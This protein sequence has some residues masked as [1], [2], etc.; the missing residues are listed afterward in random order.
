MVSKI[1]DLN[2]LYYIIVW[3]LTC[4]NYDICVIVVLDSFQF[5]NTNQLCSDIND[6]YSKI[7]NNID[8]RKA[9][10]VAVDKFFLGRKKRKVVHRVNEEYISATH[11]KGCFI[12]IIGSD[13]LV[14]FNTHPSGSRNKNSRPICKKSMISY[15][16]LIECITIYINVIEYQRKVLVGFEHI[17]DTSIIFKIPKNVSTPLNVLTMNIFVKTANAKVFIDYL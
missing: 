12:Q 10:A 16:D 17:I 6:H 5:Y 3:N 15:I 9:F 4:H 1:L 8:C 2:I 13:F 11:P 14:Y 7:E